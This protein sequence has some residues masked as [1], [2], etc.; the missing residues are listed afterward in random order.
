MEALSQYKVN[1]IIE[2][3]NVEGLT[4]RVDL[5]RVDACRKLDSEQRSKMGQF[6]TPS[7]RFEPSLAR[8]REGINTNP[9]NR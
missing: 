8:V 4:E 3:V 5:Y 9:A 1:S 7:R 6:F 2:A